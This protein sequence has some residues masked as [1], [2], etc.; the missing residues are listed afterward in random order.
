MSD[1]NHNAT[2]TV[3]RSVKRV[4]SSVRTREGGGFI[5]HRPFPTDML[6]DFDPFQLK[7]IQMMTLGLILFL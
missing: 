5:V 4:L 6:M 3:T 1:S 7:P 2:D